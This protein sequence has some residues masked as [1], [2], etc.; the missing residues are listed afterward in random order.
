MHSVQ[1]VFQ[2]TNVLQSMY[3]R[4]DFLLIASH[5]QCQQFP[6][7]NAKLQQLNYITACKLFCHSYLLVCL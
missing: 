2:E 1:V 6:L 3:A 7:Q 4:Y 5:M